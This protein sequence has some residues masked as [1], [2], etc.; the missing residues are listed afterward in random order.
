MWSSVNDSGGEFLFKIYVLKLC[1]YVQMPVSFSK[2]C[3]ADKNA[4]DNIKIYLYKLL[5]FQYVTQITSAK[6]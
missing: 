4:V 3:L 2:I 5:V 1:T 6:S